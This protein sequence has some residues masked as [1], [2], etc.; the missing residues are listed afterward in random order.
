MAKNL[1]GH[2]FTLAETTK[3]G[4]SA[5]N[6]FATVHKEEYNYKGDPTKIR[7]KMA[8]EVKADLRA[9]HFRVGFEE[10]SPFGKF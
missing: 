7:G 1:K 4:E 9:S 5:K 8:D 2:H 10:N 6:Y 3:Q